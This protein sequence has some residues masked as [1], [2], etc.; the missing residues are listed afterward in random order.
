MKKYKNFITVV[1]TASALS[2]GMAF[3]VFAEETQTGW[4]E[5]EDI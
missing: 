4:I 5:G 2:A 3:T 1:A